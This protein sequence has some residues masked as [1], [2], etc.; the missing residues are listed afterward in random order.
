MAQDAP[1][2]QQHILQDL[3]DGLIMRKAAL[4][5]RERLA[6]FHANTLLDI[7]ETAPNEGLYYW[8]L[9]LMSGTH[10]TFKPGDFVMV[11]DT[12]GKI[13]SSIGH[14]SQTWTYEGIP[15]PFGQPEI[16]S[17]DPEYRRRGLVRA[18][19]DEVHRWSAER[20]EL[21]QGVTGIAWY[22]RQFGYEMALNLGGSRA[23][24]R[25]HV[26]KLKEGESEPYRVRPA[27]VDD[28]PFVMEMHRQATSRS[29]VASI[30]SEAHWRYDIEGRSEKSDFNAQLRIIETSEGEPMGA[31]MHSRKVRSGGL[32]IFW[33]EAKP[34]VP[35]LSVTP[36]VMRYLDAT[37]VEYAKRD[38]GEF[39]AISFA[40]GEKHPLYDTISERLPRV[41]KPY[42]W[43]IRVP[44]LP[45]F[46]RHI[47]PALEKRL[48]QSA[49]SGYT[50]E[51]KVSFYSSGLLFKFDKGSIVVEGWKPGRIEEGDA[52]F[53]DLTFLQALFGYRSLEELQYAFPDCTTNTDDARALLP[54]LFPKKTSTV[55]GGG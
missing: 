48:A 18:Q 1:T 32:A 20:G 15:F 14:I 36:S 52:F 6:H 24:F 39:E 26:P 37:G 27:T 54:V 30:W 3:G 47:A 33:Y 43:Y 35:L 25:A 9:D 38:G 13:V 46:V 31:L 41:R 22:Y 12:T 51:L 45:A 55:W 2:K 34:G 11:E 10:P 21:V 7:G 40:L 53:P 23:G 17:T 5:D 19:F 8:M 50:G 42:A 49:Q 4:E 28:V 29:M 16:V 44:D